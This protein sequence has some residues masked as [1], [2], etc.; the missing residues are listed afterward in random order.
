VKALLLGAGYA[1]RLYPL[2]KNRPKPLLPIGR[3][4]MAEWIVDR[5]LAVPGLDG[6]AV[7]TNSR[8]AEAFEDWRRGYKCP[9]PVTV[10][11]DGTTS[12]D[13]RLGAVGD[14]QFTIREGKIDDDLLVVAGD[15]LFEFDVAKM[16]E[17]AKAKGGPVV[18]LKDMQHVGPLISQYSVVTLDANKRITDFEEKPAR[19]K[20]T[21]ISICLYYFP[22][23]TLQLVDK[24]LAAGHNKDQPGWYIQWLVKQVPTYG[25]VIDGLW[26]DI[27]DIDSYDKA[28]EMFEKR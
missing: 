5:L 28:N 6:V 4:P 21:L 17:F 12:N 1:T 3:K 15:N 27:G 10:F 16:V 13:D 20:T 23:A 18:C 7:V 26:F 2:T 8:F 24:Y 9:V 11:N 25:F 19:P 22:K 14:I